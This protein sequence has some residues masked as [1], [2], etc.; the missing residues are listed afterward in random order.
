MRMKPGVA[1]LF[2]FAF[3]FVFSNGR[4]DDGE[5][6]FHK[7]QDAL[8][9]ADKIA[10]V[11]D[12]EQ[13]VNAESWDGNTGRSIGAVRKRTR[14]VRPH[15]LRVDQEGPGSTYVLYFD[16]TSGWEILPGTQ[17]VVELSGG[18]LAFAQKYIRDFRLNTWLADRDPRYRVTSPA[19][20]VVRIS[21]DDPAHQRDITLDPK[22]GLP[23]RIASISLSD[24]AHPIPSE[25]VVL[26]W[27]TVAGIRFVRRW[28]VL[29]S[30]VRVAE[31]T[32]ERTIVNG[33][34]SSADLAKPPPEFA[35]VLPKGRRTKASMVGSP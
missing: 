27:E 10:A 8:G 24:P 26:E 7:M 34:L 16:G 35:P 11:H 15:Q 3:V 2:S 31:A 30:G 20:D 12:L 32:V 25:E 13:T 29:R 9:G 1:A 19:P 28:K 22:S 5:R 23:D 33:G 21:D 17:K 6:L 18:E 14:W 4:A